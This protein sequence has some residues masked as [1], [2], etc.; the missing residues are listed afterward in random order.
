MILPTLLGNIS[1]SLVC[2]LYGM[3]NDGIINPGDYGLPYGRYDMIRKETVQ[4]KP[5]ENLGGNPPRQLQDESKPIP[6]DDHPL[7]DIIGT[8][9]GP[10]WEQI[11]KNIKRNRK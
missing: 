8:H 1:G 4:E 6:G 9:E 2:R 10:I 7:N 11:L 3:W 5:M